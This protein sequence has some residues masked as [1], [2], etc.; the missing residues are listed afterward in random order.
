MTG[1]TKRGT[2]AGVAKTVPAPSAKT[3]LPPAVIDRL[4]KGLHDDV[5]SVLGMHPGADGQRQV[6]VFL[7]G[8]E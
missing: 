1:R 5:F 4:V 2:R 3:L 7:P 6:T 8:A